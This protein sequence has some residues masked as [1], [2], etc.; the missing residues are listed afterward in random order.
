M[1]RP[2][3]IW[4]GYAVLRRDA[5]GVERPDVTILASEEATVSAIVTQRMVRDAR[6]NRKKESPL[7]PEYGDIIPIV[8]VDDR[9]AKGR[10]K[11]GRAA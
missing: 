11:K 4:R 2:K 7:I 3:I 6:E 8:I 5:L 1:K 10:K 9:P